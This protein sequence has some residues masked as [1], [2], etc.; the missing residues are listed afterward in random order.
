MIWNEG[1]PHSLRNVVWPRVC[2][3]HGKKL[4]AEQTYPA[5]VKASS[6]DN[7]LTSKQIEKVRH[8]YSYMNLT[9]IS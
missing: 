2:S 6:S 3:A 8:H 9:Y 4:H 7:L 5:I 1:I